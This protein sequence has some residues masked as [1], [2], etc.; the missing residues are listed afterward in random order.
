MQIY[1]VM[2]ATFHV[3]FYKMS[4]SET[5]FK[6]KQLIYACQ[7]MFQGTRFTTYGCFCR[8]GFTHQL[9][10]ISI[11]GIEYLALILQ[12]KWFTVSQEHSLQFLIGVESKDDDMG[13]KSRS[14]SLSVYTFYF[15]TGIIPNGVWSLLLIRTMSLCIETD[16]KWIG[17]IMMQVRLIKVNNTLFNIVN[18]HACN[19]LW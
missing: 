4:K 18:L 14:Y 10:R 9:L 6:T 13:K 15:N 8:Q 16:W 17:G 19:K 11:K 3:A 7:G 5:L 2:S 1:Q 12:L